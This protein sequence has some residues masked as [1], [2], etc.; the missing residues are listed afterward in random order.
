MLP[1]L[2]ILRSLVSRLLGILEQQARVDT[3]GEA[4]NREKLLYN[5]FFI[6][7][8]VFVRR[9]PDILVLSAAMGVW[10]PPSRLRFEYLGETSADLGKTFAAEIKISRPEKFSFAAVILQRGF[11]TAYRR[12]D[13]PVFQRRKRQ[14][15]CVTPL[16]SVTLRPQTVKTFSD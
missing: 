3:P 14:K 1:D 11:E 16:K 2:G 4:V 6:R 10:K 12:A 13:N 8:A 5:N 15:C 7:P 9:R